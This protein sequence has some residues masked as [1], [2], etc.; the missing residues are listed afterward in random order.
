MGLSSDLIAQMQAEG[1]EG[2]DAIHQLAMASADQIA[3][4]NAQNAQTQANYQAA[5]IAAANQVYGAQLQ[6]AA[7]AVAVAQQVE[8]AVEKLNDW[9]D[10]LEFVLH[11]TDLVAVLVKE[12]KKKG[13]Q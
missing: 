6:Q 1:S 11:G 10:K 3:Q 5:G 9:G 12:K 13:T 8:K 7:A 4:L 2:V